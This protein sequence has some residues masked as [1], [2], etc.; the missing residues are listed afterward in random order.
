MRR[1]LLALSLVAGCY[2]VAAIKSELPVEGD[3]GGSDGSGLTEDD[4][5][6]DDDPG[7]TD[8]GDGTSGDGSDGTSG[9]GSDGTSGDGSDGTSGDGSDGD[10][11]DDGDGLTN[12]EEADLG[13]DPSNP[14]TDGDGLEDGAEVNTHGTDALNADTDGDGL[15]DGAEVN[16]HGTDALNADTDGDGLEDG[17]EVTLGADPLYEDSDFDG[18]LDGEEVNDYGTDPTNADTDG[19][20]VGDGVEVLL[21]E[22]DPNSASDDLD[23]DEGVELD[24]D[25]V[26]LLGGH[27]DVDTSTSLASV[28]SGSTDGHEHEYDDDH[29][30]TSVDWFDV[31]S[32]RLDQ[33]NHVITDVDQ[34]FKILVANADLSP[35]ARVVVNGSYDP[36]DPTSWV[37]ATTYDD[38]AV[39]DLPIYS[40]SGVTGTTQLTAFEVGF[41]ELAIPTGGLINTETGCVRSN[42]A[43]LHGEWRNGALTV[44]V[45]EVD[46][47][48]LANS[49]GTDTSLSNGGVQ[50]VATSG[51]LW[52]STI[53]WHWS[54]GSC[55]GESG[56]SA[57]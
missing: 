28:G 32:S 18:L 38:T 10:A 14:D 6:V 44:Q 56:W 51:L 36:T 27:M 53:F 5:E 9:D 43:G 54:G 17:D 48:T 42:D 39:A 2:P 37:D 50:G 7:G 21:R 34:P 33:I 57:P 23:D 4:G 12:D 11:D 40:L 13:T 52:E 31:Q 16:T 26:G 1:V 49:F 3:I 41:H 22:T 46:G 45:V 30:V 55:Y 29:D 8:G 35:G 25:D 47:S 20:S 19:G 15:E 24:D